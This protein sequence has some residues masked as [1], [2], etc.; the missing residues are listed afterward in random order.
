VRVTKTALLPGENVKASARFSLFSESRTFLLGFLGVVGGFMLRMFAIVPS[1]SGL[2][3]VI[4]VT[5]MFYAAIRGLG[6]AVNLFI[7]FLIA[8]YIIDLVLDIQPWLPVP[9]HGMKI[10]PASILLGFCEKVAW[11]SFT[12]QPAAGLWWTL[13]VSRVGLILM[14]SGFIAT[15][16]ALIRARKSEIVLT[17][18]RL[19]VR[20]GVVFPRETSIPLSAVVAVT[21]RKGLA[22][23]SLR[24][25]LKASNFEVKGLR[26]CDLINLYSILTSTVMSPCLQHEG[27]ETQ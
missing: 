10:D 1:G 15:G 7:K 21:A 12:D 20:R 9:R 6:K 2:L 5:F 13:I 23:G 8:A 18:R 3:A 14:V 27:R 11:L 4:V 16:L 26:K 17:D 24:L 22:S 19:I 25:G